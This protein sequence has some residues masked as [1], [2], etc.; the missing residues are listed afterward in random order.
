VVELLEGNGVYFIGKRHAN[1]AKQLGQCLEKRD[2][3]KKLVFSKMRRV[4]LQSY[5]GLILRFRLRIK[6]SKPTPNNTTPTGSET[7]WLVL[8]AD[9]TCSTTM[10]SKKL[11]TVPE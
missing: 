8:R 4:I 1:I 7:S 2:D 6:A 10:S 3:N 9:K 11:P 5:L